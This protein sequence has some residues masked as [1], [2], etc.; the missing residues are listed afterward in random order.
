MQ[1]SQRFYREPGPTLKRY[2]VQST[3]LM[4]RLFLV[5]C[6]WD[7]QGDFK[8]W[9]REWQ[10][11]TVFSIY[12]FLYIY[13]NVFNCHKLPQI[14]KGTREKKRSLKLCRTFTGAKIKNHCG[15]PLCWPG[16]WASAK[17]ACFD[18]Y[19]HEEEKANE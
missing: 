6:R 11:K 5:L 10:V 14:K 2:D 17:G 3:I 9:G 19:D 4:Q 12:Y 7:L 18:T 8:V 16:L 15:H 13:F 1:R